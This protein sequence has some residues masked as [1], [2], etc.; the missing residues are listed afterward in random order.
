M[1]VASL[2]LHYKMKT[3]FGPFYYIT[4]GVCT[5]KTTEKRTYFNVRIFTVWNII[6][7]NATIEHSIY[8]EDITFLLL[9]TMFSLSQQITDGAVKNLAFCCRMI[10]IL[11]LSG[12]RLVSYI[13]LLFIIHNFVIC[14]KGAPVAKRIKLLA[15]CL[16]P[17]PVA[18]KCDRFES[19]WKQKSFKLKYWFC[20]KAASGLLL[21]TVYLHTDSS[22]SF[23]DVDFEYY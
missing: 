17:M 6:F 12:C 2:L 4:F 10:N 9:D 1:H 15:K 3:I 16:I 11:N 20:E 18:F 14:I 19:C 8:V 13:I 7:L 23:G 5:I 22:S 21:L